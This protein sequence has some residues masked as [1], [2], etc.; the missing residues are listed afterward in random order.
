MWWA[1]FFGVT[2]FLLH[3]LAYGMYAREVLRERVKPNAATWGMWLVGSVVEWQ[4]YDHMMG[5][6]WSTSALPFACVL[7]L[8]AIFAATIASQMR[9][10]AR[11]STKKVYHKPEWQDWGLVSFDLFALW[12][13]LSFDMAEQ[14]NTIAVATTIVTFIPI[15]RTT[16]REPQSERPAMWLIWSAAYACMFTALLL[17]ESE[18]MWWQGFYPAYYFLLHGVVAILAYRAPRTAAIA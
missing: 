7:G 16:W 10:R 18:N 3:L 8:V 15:W 9:E 14:A 11:G 13:W 4:T 5:A 12:L 6:H 17:G 1:E 2:A